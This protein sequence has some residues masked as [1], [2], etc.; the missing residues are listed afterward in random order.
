MS[1][2]AKG[3]L[4]DRWV[5]LTA[6]LCALLYAVRIHS[7]DTWWHLATGRWIWA[8]RTIPQADPF[9]FVSGGAP[10]IYVD[11]LPEVV[12][13]ATWAVGGFVGLVL[14]KMLLAGTTIAAAGMAAR[15]AGA[16]PAA[17]VGAMLGLA[18]LAQTRFAMLRPNAFGVVFLALSMWAMLSWAHAPA[19]AGDPDAKTAPRFPRVAWLPV[20]ATLWMPTHGSAILSLGVAGVAVIGALMVG[21]RIRGT[22]AAICALGAIA[23]LFHIL[24]SGRHILDVVQALDAGSNALTMTI[25]WKRTDFTQSQT[26][27]PAAFVL[28]GLASAGIRSLRDRS[29]L[30]VLGLAIG[31]AWLGRGYERNLAE[32]VL[33]ATPAVAV[34]LSAIADAVARKA[35]ALGTTVS[36]VALGAAFGVAHVSVEPDI[37]LNTRFGFGTDEARYPTDTFET[38]LGLPSGRPGETLADLLGEPVIDPATGRPAP[39]DGAPRRTINS[40]GIGGW[41]IWNEVPGGVFADGRTVAVYTDAM[42]DAEIL[43]AQRDTAGLDATA[44][45]YNATYGLASTGSLQF[46]ILMTSPTWV[47]IHHGA[48]TSLFARRDVADEVAAAGVPI[49]HALRWDDDAAWTQGWYAGVMGSPQGRADLAQTLAASYRQ[50]PDNPVLLAVVSH[51]E[52]HHAAHLPEV[53]GPLR[54]AASASAP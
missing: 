26:W 5:P 53:L 9:G 35:S 38:L 37:A 24:P 49:L 1:D 36:A 22:R 48:S 31:G 11:W 10:W 29:H 13:Y 30:Y 7:A 8:H 4:G 16:R 21:R 50:T 45:K 27:V 6:A 52:L 17:A 28:F 23:A 34:G 42:W 40:F 19:A 12:M 33:M 46:R 51:L 25:E 20:L 15:R 41:L 44:E 43:P 39:A 32:A 47:P 18:V 3:W 2:R 14:L 54:V